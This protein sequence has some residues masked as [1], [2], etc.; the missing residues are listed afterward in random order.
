[1]IEDFPDY[2]ET[3]F[4]VLTS[5]WLGIITALLAVHLVLAAVISRPW[6]SFRVWS[7]K[8]LILLFLPILMLF[9]ASYL[10]A[11]I[12]VIRSSYDWQSLIIW[13]VFI[14]T[15]A[16]SIWTSVVARGLR[17]FTIAFSLLV[18]WFSV[19]SFGFSQIVVLN[20]FI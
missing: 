7:L 11:P 8:F 18:L 19:V 16:V 9:L 15:V 13:G 17:W 12:G 5:D 1:M 14:S 6:L 10:Q 2:L 4:N 20:I 3:C